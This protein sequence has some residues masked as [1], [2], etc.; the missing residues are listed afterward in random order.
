MAAPAPTADEGET[1]QAL[2][3]LSLTSDLESHQLI[4]LLLVLGKHRCP[5]IWAEQKPPWH[6][7]QVSAAL[8]WHRP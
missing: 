5:R 6:S 3:L 2:L 4:R 8:Q 7:R 1:D